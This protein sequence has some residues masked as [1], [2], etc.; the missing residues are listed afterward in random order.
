MFKKNKKVYNKRN[1]KKVE[2]VD[3]VLYIGGLDKE[4]FPFLVEKDSDS[5]DKE[6]TNPLNKIE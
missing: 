3:P 6:V 4:K 5:Y 2:L 1:K